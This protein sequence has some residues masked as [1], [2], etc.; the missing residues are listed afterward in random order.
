MKT[1]GITGSNIDGNLG[2]QSMFQTL[3]K[4]QY[5]LL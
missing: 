2:G 5:I 4:V 3:S 1:I